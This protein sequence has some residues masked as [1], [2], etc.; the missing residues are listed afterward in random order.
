MI[1]T[2]A[3]KATEIMI[4]NASEAAR[5]FGAEF[6]PRGRN[7][8]SN[9][10]K[11]VNEPVLIA[12]ANRLIYYK[13]LNTEPF[14]Y[15]PNSAMFRAKSYLKT[16]KD[17]FINACGLKNGMSVAD[18][19][20]GLGSDT[21]L[22]SLVVGKTGKVFGT[23]ANPVISYILKEGLR[24]YQTNH[25]LINQAMRRI[26]VMNRHHL[27]WL[28]EQPDSSVDVVYFDPMFEEDVKGSP[29]ILPLKHLALSSPADGSS[30]LKVLSEAKR[31]AK[32]RVVL[33]DHYRS[34]RFEEGSFTVSV[35]TSA[36]YHFGV[37]E[38]SRDGIMD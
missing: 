26:K 24:T 18:M 14:F 28:A 22:A 17:P 2:T 36:T 20:L 7:S 1:V 10:L 33:K 9:M 31:V 34:R 30:F 38:K 25:D 16:K 4:K 6:R 23:E 11:K 12:E 21:V 27:D 15:H 32:V 19:T 37:W 13:D 5:V 8:V 3:P 29:G 35:R